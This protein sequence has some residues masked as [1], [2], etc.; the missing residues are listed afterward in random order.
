MLGA[1]LHIFPV[2][3]ISLGPPPLAD[4]VHNLAI[5]NHCFENRVLSMKPV[6]AMHAELVEVVTLV[7]KVVGTVDT[8]E[9]VLLC[10]GLGFGPVGYLGFEQ[11]SSCSSGLIAPNVFVVTRHCWRIC[12]LRVVVDTR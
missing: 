9:A 5:D 6:A 12:L 2:V 10:V 3:N 7:V 1:V 4:N 11:D 8:V